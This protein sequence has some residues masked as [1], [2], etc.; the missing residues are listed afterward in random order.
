METIKRIINWIVI[1]SENPKKVSLTLRGLA[2]TIIPTLLIY[3]ADLIPEVNYY[4]D[5]L[6][7]GVVLGLEVVAAFAAFYGFIRKIQNTWFK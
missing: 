1:S 4:V 7:I 2:A 5:A 3:N 6:I